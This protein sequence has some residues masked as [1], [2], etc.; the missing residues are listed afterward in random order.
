MF[1]RGVV[2]FA[3]RLPLWLLVATGLVLLTLGV[4]PYLRG[5]ESLRTRDRILFGVLRGLAVATLLFCLARPTLVV[6]AAVPQRNV[7]GIVVD[8]SRSMRIADVG[9][10]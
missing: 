8:D 5:A 3:S 7:V 4:W 1:E 10:T 9:G 2:G 6:A